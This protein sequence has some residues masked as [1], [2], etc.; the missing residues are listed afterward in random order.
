MSKIKY[1]Q[2]ILKYAKVNNISNEEAKKQLEDQGEYYDEETQESDL[3]NAVDDREGSLAALQ[4][5][6]DMA[7][8]GTVIQN[9]IEQES[10]IINKEEKRE[11]EVALEAF[12][13]LENK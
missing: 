2:R 3:K 9:S 13:R 6:A 12:L 11:I 8:Q 5:Q 1:N 4:K 10:N 7:K